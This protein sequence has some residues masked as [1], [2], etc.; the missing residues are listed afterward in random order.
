MYAYDELHDWLTR[1][2]ATITRLEGD[3]ARLDGL[4]ASLPQSTQPPAYSAPEGT[5]VP[6][7]PPP[8]PPYVYHDQTN[9][10][11]PLRAAASDAGEPGERG[12][13]TGSPLVPPRPDQGGAASAPAAPDCPS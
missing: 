13:E 1:L 5:A 4:V 9:Q 6:T 10:P 11:P 7:C 12:L 2:E 8:Y 3:V